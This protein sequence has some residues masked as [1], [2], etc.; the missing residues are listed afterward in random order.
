MRNRHIL[1]A[2]LCIVLV[3]SFITAVCSSSYLYYKSLPASVNKRFLVIDARLD[4]YGTNALLWMFGLAVAKREGYT[5]VHVCGEGC[6]RNNFRTKAFHLAL[7][8]LASTH[9]AMDDSV[10]FN[11]EASP[12]IVKL[13]E[14]F[15]NRQDNPLQTILNAGMDVHF[16]DHLSRRCSSMKK[17]FDD[18]QKYSVIHQRLEDVSR[19]DRNRATQAPYTPSVLNRLLL[20][21]DNFLAERNPSNNAATNVVVTHPKSRSSLE[22]SMKSMEAYK[23]N[24]FPIEIAAPADEDET[25]WFMVRSD[26]LVC[27]RSIF[28]ISAAVCRFARTDL[29]RQEIEDTTRQGSSAYPF[30]HGEDLCGRG[31]LSAVCDQ[32]NY[33]TRLLRPMISGER[34]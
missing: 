30:I 3:C 9:Y 26:V 27:G 10:V 23:T 8:A 22:D 18:N 29:S 15:P 1:T 17:M 16:H 13:H 21:T 32:R 7:T 5:A 20:Q 25:L 4:R 34:D 28:S 11:M 33:G 31:R 12:Y 24:R 14:K 2:S 19:A 6:R